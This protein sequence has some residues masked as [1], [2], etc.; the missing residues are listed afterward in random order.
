MM[1]CVVC[2]A[3][4]SLRGGGAQ[5]YPL[6]DAVMGLPSPE[7]LTVYPDD[8]DAKLFY[9]VPTSFAFAR[10]EKGKPRLGVQYWG[11]TG[12]DPES[13]GASF[14]FSIQPA[15]DQ[16]TLDG[17]LVE[18]RKRNPHAVYVFPPLLGSSLDVLLDGAW[19][20]GN[21]DTSSPNST[22]I[23]GKLSTVAGT[24]DSGQAFTI[25]VANVGARVFARP[26]ASAENWI[27]ARYRYRFL[28]V[29]KR[30]HA[31]VTLYPKRIYDYFK[32]NESGQA[33]RP[34]IGNAWSGDWQ[35]LISQ[36]S[37]AIRVLDSGEP[38]AGAYMAE[39]LDA[40]VAQTIKSETLFTPELRAGGHADTPE[41]ASFGWSFSASRAWAEIDPDTRQ[42]YIVDTKKLVEREISVGLTFSAACGMYPDR[43]SDL[44]L[45]GR[46]CIDSGGFQAVAQ[47]TKSCLDAKLTDLYTKNRG[48]LIPSAVLNALIASAY[49]SPCIAAINDGRMAVLLTKIHTSAGVMSPQAFRDATDRCRDTR[50]AD[51][52]KH[53]VSGDISR[54]QWERQVPL[55]FQVPCRNYVKVLR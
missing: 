22:T 31:E 18:L 48:G 19:M 42:T 6:F 55:V 40:L 28:G 53:Y 24:V 21:Q 46:K 14:R 32:T 27:A 7:S 51:V 39:V 20:P 2:V 34:T 50:L 30:L 9:F 47:S 23:G 15:F 16:S 12:L 11:L 8:T 33:W 1:V 26:A 13:A 43:F 44:T 25:A 41:T 5:A 49:D 37:V 17:I 54:E 29:G 35:A 38:D 52:K 36:G 45:I 4:L 3:L 10:D